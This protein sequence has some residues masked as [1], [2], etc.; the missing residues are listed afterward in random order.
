MNKG[1][2]WQE[3]VDHW[4]VKSR[5]RKIVMTNNEYWDSC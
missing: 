5:E 1:A 4:P 2:P 3:T